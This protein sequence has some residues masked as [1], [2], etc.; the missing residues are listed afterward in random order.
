MAVGKSTIGKALSQ[1]MNYEFYDSDQT[2]EARTGADVSWIFDVE[3]EAGFRR[4]EEAVIDELSQMDRVVLA[5]GGGAILSQ[6]TRERLHD[7]GFV[8]HLTAPIKILVDRTV[9]DKKRPILQQSSD[10]EAIF[11][12]IL[13]QR[14][15][16]YDEAAHFRLNTANLGQKRVIKRIADVFQEFCDKQDSSGED[17]PQD[18]PTAS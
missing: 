18:S 7:R 5:T 16:L 1:Y 10:R 15:P 2:I 14:G 9:Y 11:R 17:Q 3:G 12:R 8:I 6:L 13:E 4:R